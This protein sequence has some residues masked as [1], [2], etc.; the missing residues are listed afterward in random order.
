MYFNS[1]GHTHAVNISKHLLGYLGR[2][3][4]ILFG[5]LDY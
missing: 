4:D 5:Q 3:R 2:W 1:V